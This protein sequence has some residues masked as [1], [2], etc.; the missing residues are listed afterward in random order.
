MRLADAAAAYGWRMLSEHLRK[1]MQDFQSYGLALE[2]LALMDHPR[3]SDFHGTGI[4]CMAGDARDT[5]RARSIPSGVTALLRRVRGLWVREDGRR[6]AL[7][8]AYGS[9]PII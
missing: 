2:A 7:P 5:A 6:P 1:R 4:V 8:S 3:W 9:A